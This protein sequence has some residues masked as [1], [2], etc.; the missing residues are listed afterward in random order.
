M[1]S[2]EYFTKNGPAMFDAPDDATAERLLATKADRDPA[3]GVRR[4][5]GAP[6]PAPAAAPA[7]ATLPTPQQTDYSSLAKT[8]G[9]AGVS[10]GDYSKLFTPTDED[11]K[12][13]QD[14]IAKQFGY[15]DYGDF[16]T[17]AFAA[18]SQTTQDFFSSA[19]SAAGLDKLTS[20]I[21]EKKNKLTQALGVVN[22]NP[23]Y[24]EAFRRG[25]AARLQDLAQGDIS[26]LTDEYNLRLGHVKDLLT[27]YSTDLAQEEK[28]R[29]AQLAYLEKYA[30]DAATRAAASRA[31]EYLSEYVAAKQ[32]TAE[33]KTVS[34]PGTNNLYQY[35][36][37]TGAWN[38]VQKGRIPATQSGG[39]GGNVTDPAVQYYADLLRKGMISLA[40]VP[41][42]IRNAVVLASQGDI[43]TRLSDTALKD[44]Q[45]SQGAIA[46][47]QALRS[48][49]EANLQYLG[50]VAGVSALNPYSKARQVQAEIDRVKQQV[51]KAL[52]GG[53]LRKEDEEKYKKILATI[54]DT[55]ETA[56]AKIDNLITSIQRDVENYTSLQAATGRYV[57]PSGGGSANVQTELEDDIRNAPAGKNREELISQLVGAYPELTIDQIAAKVYALIPD[58]KP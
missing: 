28:M 55:P 51:G 36:A 45:Q 56:L 1:A 41:T 16:I 32:S 38:L 33:P 39:G 35:D 2:Y 4:L 47:L 27:N 6:A 34:V 40:N 30:T 37:A 3:S 24:D 13:A 43:N 11:T 22:D 44:I 42:N 10:Y 52:E 46:N 53:V 29:Q 19:Y 15:A 49:M 8:A 14:T 54:N 57:P 50:P 48:T 7:V 20:S 58:K 21:T 18:P 31:S 12:A 25:E 9:A 17:K 5:P 23:W 26:N